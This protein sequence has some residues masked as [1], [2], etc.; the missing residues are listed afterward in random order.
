MQHDTPHMP[1][2]K[3][4]LAKKIG[5]GVGGLVEN[6]MSNGIVLLAL[7][8]FNIGLGVNAVWLGW[9]LALPRLIDAFLDPVIGNISDNTRSRW[10]RR[11]PYVFIGGMAC[12]LFFALVWLPP[13]GWSQTAVFTYFAVMSFCYYL[14]LSLFSVPYNALGIELTEDYTERTNV[15]A[16]RFFFISISGIAVA[17][18]YKLS[19]HPFFTGGAEGPSGHPE[20]IGVRG[21]A[22]CTALLIMLAA[23]VPFF[24]SRESAASQKQQKITLWPALRMTFTNKAFLLLS[25]LIIVALLGTFMVEPFALYIG[26]YHVFDGNKEMAATM[27]GWIGVAKNAGSILAIPVISWIAARIGKKNTLFVG[28]GLLAVSFLSSWVCFTPAAPWLMVVPFVFLAPG[29]TCFMIMGGSML[30]DVCD[31]DELEH[32]MRREGMFG[33]AAG[34]VGKFAFS[35]V[36]VLNGYLLAF[37]GFDPQLPAQSGATVLSLRLMF[38]FVPLVLLAAS[39]VLTLWFPIGQR[40]AAEIRAAL[41]ARPKPALHSS[42]N[43]LTS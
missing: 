41:N 38:V 14:S 6:F 24:M 11:R 34:F 19:F 8:I 5:W 10:G 3:L 4:P 18:I 26:I 42:T 22:V 31:Q 17:W 33:A 23:L 7:P 2:G 25:T 15:Q 35:L 40:R 30:G 29:L 16:W 20:V 28:Q 32:G 39:L 21:V 37:A 36:T 27:A 12:A 43:D 13:L 9:A 1:P